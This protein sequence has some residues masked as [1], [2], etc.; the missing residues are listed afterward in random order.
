MRRARLGLFVLAACMAGPIL[1]QDGATAQ[2]LVEQIAAQGP[3]LLPD[4]Q[5]TAS[6]ACLFRGPL[7][8]ARDALE[9][10]A[11]LGDAGV[12]ALAGLLKHP[13][14]QVR[15]NAAYALGKIGGPAT[16]A[17]LINASADPN[18]GVRYLVAQAIGFTSSAQALGA[19]IQLSGDLDAE[20]RNA[21][22]Q[23]GAVLGE[24][25]LAEQAETTDAKLA[26]LVK[27]TVNDAGVQHLARYGAAA[28][29]VLL[30]ALDNEDKGVVAGAARTLAQI[31]DARGLQPLWDHFTASLKGSPET[32]FAQ[33][34][35]LYR[36]PQVFEYL[37]KMLD[38]VDLPADQAPPFATGLAQ[39]FALERLE[40]IDHPD[41]LKVVNAFLAKL[42]TKGQHK[43][44]VRNAETQVSAVATACEVLAKIGDKSSLPVIDQVIAEAPA[45]EKSIV[46]PI[47][48]RAKTAIEQ[49]GA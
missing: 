6:R 43:E 12:P 2:R 39:H 21:A 30:T 25:L 44:V 16:A 19:L 42:V 33:A 46:K 38:T 45:P 24:I 7:Q 10:L 28:V 35:G 31:G 18:A 8:P 9:Q 26:E 4:Q 27:L 17:P 29:P 41:R 40:V 11:A 37:T 23:T 13:R 36:N 34:L 20:V 15:A 47:A 5:V 3:Q 22:I 48:Q 14:A 32:K 1:A 49:R